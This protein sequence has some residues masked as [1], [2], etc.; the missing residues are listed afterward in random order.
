MTQDPEL[1][2]TAWPTL[3]PD[4]RLDPKAPINMLPA[5]RLFDSVYVG[6][7][8]P[9]FLLNECIKRG[10]EDIH[11]RVERYEKTKG[12]HIIVANLGHGWDAYFV[13]ED[14]GA[15]DGMVVQLY[16]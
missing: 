16:E 4:Y 8:T 2:G 13:S 5:D 9:R 12:G 7:L 11:G 3:N 10:W 6:D 1:T 15:D 14:E